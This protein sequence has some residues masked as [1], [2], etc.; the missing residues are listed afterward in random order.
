MV[1]VDQPPCNAP[2]PQVNEILAQMGTTLKSEDEEKAE[3]E[4]RENEDHR[5]KFRTTVMFSATMNKTLADIAKKYLR[6]PVQVLV[7][8]SSSTHNKDIEHLMIFLRKDAKDQML[9]KLLH[10]NRDGSAIVF[11]NQKVQVEAVGKLLYEHNIRYITFHSGKKQN[12]RSDNID[13][14]KRGQYRVMVATDVASRG[15]DI[16]GL[17]LVVNYDFPSDGEKYTH[18]C[19][20]KL[21]RGRGEEGAG[22]AFSPFSLLNECA[23]TRSGVSPPTPHPLRNGTRG[24]QGNGRHVHDGRRH[25]DA[26]DGVPRRVQ[27]LPRART[28]HPQGNLVQQG[29]ARGSRALATRGGRPQQHRR[30]TTVCARRIPSQIASRRS[31][32]AHQPLHAATGRDASLQ[33]TP[34]VRR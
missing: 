33:R 32:V 3:A 25:H 18:R 28:H 2:P 13:A 14:F 6:H 5:S 16:D 15:L 23:S 10:N 11:C 30:L 17:T 22:S 20:S 8:D 19:G 31:L 34:R 7:G 21:R 9:L 26:G 29:C 27:V 12:E 24:E 4:A 1:D